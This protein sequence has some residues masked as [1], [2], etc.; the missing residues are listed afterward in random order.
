MDYVMHLIRE[1]V[2]EKMSIT[3][4]V[5]VVYSAVADLHAQ[6]IRQRALR[7]FIIM[8]RRKKHAMPAGQ[9]QQVNRTNKIQ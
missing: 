8:F 1:G 7:H 6:S 4:T 2:A 5:R 3:V 9:M